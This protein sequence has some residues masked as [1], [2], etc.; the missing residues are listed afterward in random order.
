MI[1]K[2]ELDKR[3]TLQIIILLGVVWLCYWPSISSFFLADDIWQVSFAHKVFDGRTELIWRNF[4]SN[5]LQLPSF[6][7]YRPLMGFTFLFDYFLNG[8]RPAGYH[9]TNI[10]LYSI[11]S[12]LMLF[13]MRAL[14]KSWP[15]FNAEWASFLTALLFAL[16]PLHCEDV[17][18][19]SGRA[20][21]LS[22]PFYL[23]ALYCIVRSHQ[24]KNR[25]LYW[26][27]LAGFW[28]AI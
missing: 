17:A 5:Y 23:A 12:V 15:R 16:S 25:K 27:G 18:W 10:T 19:I 13:L 7:F 14:T 26:I 8:A 9:L 28:G 22:A 21:I 4:T 11:I 6:D 1:G 24:E 3:L 20:D 2:K